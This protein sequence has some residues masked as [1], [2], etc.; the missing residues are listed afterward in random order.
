[1][2]DL[3]YHNYWE[4]KESGLLKSDFPEDF[5]PSPKL[6]DH[7]TNRYCYTVKV[8][9]ISFQLKADYF[10]GVDWLKENH[11]AIIIAPKLNT[12]FDAIKEANDEG[13]EIE[14]D[15]IIAVNNNKGADV[16]I[17]YFAMLNQCLKSDYLYDEI[18]NLAQI[19]WNSAEILIL[20][21]Q[22]WISPLIIVKFLKQLHSI[23]RKG[24]KKGYY[25]TVQNL[26]SKVKGK[27]LI[28]QNIRE[29][30]LK[31]RFINTVCQYEEFGVNNKENRLLKKALQFTIAY[32]DFNKKLFGT[33]NTNFTEIINFCRP[34]FENVST[35]IEVHEI[36]QFKSNP[37]FKE[38][39]EGIQLAK[40]I[41]K[42]YAYNISNTS[43]EKVTT[44]PYWIDMPKLFE[45]YAYK[46]LR[47]RFPQ[48]KCLQYHLRTYGNELDYLVNSDGLQMVIDAKYKPLYIYGKNHKDMRQVSGYARLEK[49]YSEL[50]VEV[51][52]II[53]CL[54]IY[55]DVENGF[56]E[57]SFK[58][59][60]LKSQPIK[61]YRNIYKIG[62]KLPVR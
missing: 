10:I 5:M 36:K 44:P 27:I 57:A 12:R 26:N 21:E 15:E 32:L 25:Q 40:L 9:E 28:S 52:R 8:S 47:N 58:D 31:N 13:C 51:D 61:G 7:I 14:F 48:N 53:D 1:M 16:F 59:V 49:V 6:F 22:D 46:F 3:I 42:R 54:I 56:N 60:N 30:V 39:N 34:A 24:L 33:N 19:N 43:K 17:D 37:F 29:N 23:V 45:L 41:L 11:S 50:K 35:D 20:Q 18:D 55:P 62:I 2:S 38:Y 4:H